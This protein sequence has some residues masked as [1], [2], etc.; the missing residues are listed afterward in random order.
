MRSALLTLDICELFQPAC[1][2]NS[3]LCSRSNLCLSNI[4]ELSHDF[5]RFVAQ[6]LGQEKQIF[7]RFRFARKKNTLDHDNYESTNCCPFNGLPSKFFL[8]HFEPFNNGNI[9]ARLHPSGFSSPSQ[10]AHKNSSCLSP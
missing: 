1:A 8:F 2:E 6:N 9:R 10:L 5:W 4:S 7:S 3:F